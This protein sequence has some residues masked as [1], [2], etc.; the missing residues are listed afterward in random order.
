MTTWSH[1]AF[2]PGQEDPLR[3][4]SNWGIRLSGIQGSQT[5]LGVDDGRQGERGLAG[6]PWLR[7]QLWYRLQGQCFFFPPPL[8]VALWKPSESSSIAI[9][10]RQTAI[11]TASPTWLAQG[12]PGWLPSKPSFPLTWWVAE[13]MSGSVFSEFQEWRAPL[14]KPSPQKTKRSSGVL[15]KSTHERLWE[16]MT[17][18]ERTGW[19][20]RF[21]S[22][23]SPTAQ[24]FQTWPRVPRL[25]HGF[26]PDKTNCCRPARPGASRN[27]QPD[28][29]F[30]L[31][32]RSFWH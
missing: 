30:R 32:S 26:L 15:D 2:S 11:N 27:S 12:P 28:P 23:F 17:S 1:R 18:T 8:S 6:E 7:A 31:P 19:P 29:P 25:G 9:T 4:L 3:N 16:T 20:S 22:W 14:H 24:A 13:G 21:T 10:F 5:W